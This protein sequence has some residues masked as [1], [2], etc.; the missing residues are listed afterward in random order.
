MFKN[1]QSIEVFSLI[2]SSRVS[3]YYI[4]HLI[5]YLHNTISLFFIIETPLYRRAIIDKVLY[6]LVDEKSN[7]LIKAR[8]AL[9]YP[10]LTK[11]YKGDDA[12]KDTVLGILE[13]RNI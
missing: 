7:E 11:R 2:Q 1:A 6:Q 12:E 10:L 13:I 5:T 8:S 9:L 3:L 4:Y